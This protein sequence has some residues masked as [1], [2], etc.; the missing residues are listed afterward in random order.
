MYQ[1]V[2][3]CV[4]D[5]CFKQLA[6]LLPGHRVPTVQTNVKTFAEKYP[7]GSIESQR[8]QQALWG[9]ADAFWTEI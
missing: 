9:S 1:P 2:C 7:V 6:H 4:S 8:D 5:A 3:L